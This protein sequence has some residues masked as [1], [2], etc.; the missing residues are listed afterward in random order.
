MG[1][2]FDCKQAQHTLT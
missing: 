2:R 1:S